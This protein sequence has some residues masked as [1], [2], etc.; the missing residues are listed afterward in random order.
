LERVIAEVVRDILVRDVVAHGPNP[1]AAIRVVTSAGG[2]DPYGRSDVSRVVIGGTV[3]E[4]VFLFPTIGVAESIDPGNFAQEE[5]ALILLDLLSGPSDDPTAPLGGAASLNRYMTSASDRIGFIGRVLGQTA[6]HEAG[7]FYG[8]FHTD[9]VDATVCLMDGG[10]GQSPA[11]AFGVGPDGVGGTDDD[12]RATFVPAAYDPNEAFAGI[13][14]TR[15][16]TAFGLS[17]GRR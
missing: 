16:V 4:A 8:N 15:A 10:P 3:A 12:V 9:P 1:A 14:D 7:H 5:T 11:V 13:Q 17:R 6:A 2:I